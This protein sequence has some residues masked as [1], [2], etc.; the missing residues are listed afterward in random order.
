MYELLPPPPQLEA[1]CE[2]CWWGPS[3]SVAMQN[4]SASHMPVPRA[5]FQVPDTNAVLDQG[6]KTRL[7]QQ[8]L[9]LCPMGAGCRFTHGRDSGVCLAAS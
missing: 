9:Y 3:Y 4:E 6:I 2:P 5:T 7:N 1:I 8:A